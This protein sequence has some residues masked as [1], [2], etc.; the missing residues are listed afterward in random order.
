MLND[1]NF[2]SKATSDKTGNIACK[3]A[4]LEISIKKDLI[5]IAKVEKF[6]SNLKDPKIRQAVILHY[7]NGS[8]W[9]SVS[10]SMG[11]NNPHTLEKQVIRYFKK[12]K[13]IKKY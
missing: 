2:P 13:L 12:I 5:K 10:S 11:E 9:K 3:I 7:L 4:D 1:N 8:T 6:C